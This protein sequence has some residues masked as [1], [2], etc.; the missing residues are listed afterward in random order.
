MRTDESIR[1]I[2]TAA[3]KRKAM[4]LETWTRTQLWDQWSETI[5][6]FIADRAAFAP[7]ELGIIG[8]LE[9]DSYGYLITTQRILIYENEVVRAINIDDIESYDFGMKF[10][11]YAGHQTETVTLQCKEGRK[12]QFHFETGYPSMGAIYGL[13]TVLTVGRAKAD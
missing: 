1:N 8:Y 11:G 4:H 7:T 6:K 5:K 13:M 10:K 9:S 3:I 2:V 12:D